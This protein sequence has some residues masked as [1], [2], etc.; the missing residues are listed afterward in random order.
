MRYRHRA[1]KPCVALWGLMAVLLIA[2]GLPTMVALLGA[3]TVT[4]LVLAGWLLVRRGGL[5]RHPSTAAAV[6]RRRA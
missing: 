5:A 3:V 1:G 2:A 4:V 6:P